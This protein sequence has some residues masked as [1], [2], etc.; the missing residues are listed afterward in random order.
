[1]NLHGPPLSAVTSAVTP[2][3]CGVAPA[4]MSS[5]SPT[6]LR[7]SPASHVPWCI[8]PCTTVTSASLTV[9]VTRAFCAASV[10]ALSRRSRGSTRS[11]GFAMPSLLARGVGS[12]THWLRSSKKT[13]G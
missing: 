4:A 12:N 3:S 8:C 10:L 5:A 7:A 2:M 9:S 1:M 6:L 11:P 13:G